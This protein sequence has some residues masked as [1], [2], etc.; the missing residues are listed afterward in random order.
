MVE[1]NL[2]GKYSLVASIITSVVITVL[3]TFLA[4]LKNNTDTSQMYTQVDII[5]GTLFVFLL[6]MIVSVSIWPSI[7]EKY[8]SK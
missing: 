3:F 6:T 7:I 4:I 5:G 8:A 2:K 1:D